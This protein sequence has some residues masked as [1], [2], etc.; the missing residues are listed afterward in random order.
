MPPETLAPVT[1]TTSHSPC[2]EVYGH[3]SRRQCPKLLGFC[4]DSTPTVT[5]QQLSMLLPTVI[6]QQLGWPAHYKRSCLPP[7]LPYLLFP[8]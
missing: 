7:P 2:R 4:L 1:A 5:W 8:L 3:Q 6:R